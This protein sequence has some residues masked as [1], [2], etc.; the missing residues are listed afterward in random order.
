MQEVAHCRAR[1]DNRNHTTCEAMRRSQLIGDHIVCI[2][3]A[4]WIPMRP[5][6]HNNEPGLGNRLLNPGHERDAQLNVFDIHEDAGD[7]TQTIGE[8]VYEE[9]TIT[10]SI[11]DEDFVHLP[12]Q[13][14]V[15]HELY[16]S[17]CRFGLH[18]KERD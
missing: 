18:P 11:R 15:C 6:D 9:R 5:N 13:L 7:A 10:P 1:E 2:V 17:E 16:H 4:R 8:K 12:L 3:Q 14:I